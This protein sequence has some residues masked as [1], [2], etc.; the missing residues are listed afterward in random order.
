[1]AVPES[2]RNHVGAIRSART[3]CIARFVDGSA[4]FESISLE[5]TSSPE[6]QDMYIVKLLE[7][8]PS[9]GKVRARRLLAELGLASDVSFVSIDEGHRRRIAG[10]VDTMTR[11]A[12]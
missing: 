7:A 2:V 4:S 8:H 6:L 12:L 11:S 9:V 5:A 1:M 3:N 10:A